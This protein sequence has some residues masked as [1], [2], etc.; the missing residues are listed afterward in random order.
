MGSDA[1]T[2]AVCIPTVPPRV[3]L[4]WQRAIP[5]VRAQTRPCDE[6]IVQHDYEGVGAGATRNLAWQAATSD[7]VAF[8][9]DDDELLPEHLEAC[10]VALTVTGADLAYPWFELVGWEDATADRPDPLAT[11]RHGELVHP[12]GVPFGPEQ[13]QHVREHA[14]IPATVVVRRELL[15][16]VGGYPEPNSEDYGRYQHCEDWAL[17]N[18]LLDVDAKFVHVPKRTWR[19]HLG[20]GTAG[21]NWRLA[22]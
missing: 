20:R 16:A 10:L 17:L 2:V 19:L 8:L 13:A 11:R 6:L 14:W 21:Q 1:L 4:L 7:Y 18:R 9:D 15:Q 3:D 5:S 12:L 22:S